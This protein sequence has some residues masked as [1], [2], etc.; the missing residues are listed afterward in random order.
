[1]LCNLTTTSCYYSQYLTK[2]R[3]IKK[4]R[5]LISFILQDQITLQKL[6]GYSSRSC[7]ANVRVFV[8]GVLICANL[9]V[10]L[11]YFS[12]VK[13]AEWDRSVNGT[14]W[15]KTMILKGVDDFFHFYSFT[16]R[17]RS[18]CRCIS[19]E[20]SPLNQKLKPRNFHFNCIFTTVSISLFHEIRN[21][22]QEIS[23]QI[24]CDLKI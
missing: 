21:G 8:I 4:L 13:F 2:I 23:F 11:I 5:E 10:I 6:V 17:K 15:P 19:M 3:A 20:V 1:M 24:Y 22:A 9:F 12:R 14:V 16:I 18:L 7:R